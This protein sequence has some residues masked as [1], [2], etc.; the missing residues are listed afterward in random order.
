MKFTE[1]IQTKQFKKFLTKLYS[2]GASVVII[3]ALFKIEHWPMADL[4]LCTGL[5][6]EAVIF[7]FFA[8]DNSDDEQAATLPKIVPTHNYET[9]ELQ[10]GEQNRVAID[11]G[12]A[13]GGFGGGSLAL[14]KFDELLE[15]AEITPEM[16]Y[17]LGEGMKKLGESTAN[18]NS[19]GDISAASL[20]YMNTIQ[21]ADESLGKLA[22][23]YQTTIVKVISK[24]GFNYKNISESLSAI[25]EGAKT[26]QQQLES[27]NK[28][29]SALNTVYVLQKKEADNYLKDLIESADDSRKYKEQIKTLNN[30]LSALNSVYG[31]MLTAMKVK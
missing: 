29:L 8:F 21:A 5:L 26:Y 16:F 12:V 9:E 7:F 22:K 23:S 25:E 15:N 19:I 31:N 24:T 14:A 3:G 11:G 13:V 6:T 20:K 28:N 30:N 17:K 2:I 1:L 4:M 18:I 10:I 27:L